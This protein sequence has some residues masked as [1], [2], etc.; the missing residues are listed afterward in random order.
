MIHHGAHYAVGLSRS[1]LFY[2]QKPRSVER[3]LAFQAQS[4]WEQARSHSFYIYQKWKLVLSKAV[5]P[6]AWLAK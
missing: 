1:I 5:R 3:G 2:A 4:M 6:A